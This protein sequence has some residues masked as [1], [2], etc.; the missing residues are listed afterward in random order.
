M[1]TTAPNPNK[2]TS[3]ENLWWACEDYCNS[4]F[5]A[6]RRDKTCPDQNAKKEA[7]TA[8]L[9]DERTTKVFEDNKAILRATA[10][11]KEPGVNFDFQLSKIPDTSSLCVEMKYYSSKISKM[12]A[13]GQIILHDPSYSFETYRGMR[14]L[15]NLKHLRDFA[16]SKNAKMAEM[17][18]NQQHFINFSD[19]EELSEISRI[20]N[21]NPNAHIVAIESIGADEMS[22]SL[23]RK[24]CGNSPYIKT[25]QIKV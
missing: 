18:L 17:I 10:V 1:N 14:V 4:V 8:F 11:C 20:L 3:L 25:W 23:R 24:S 2:V 7:V 12:P 22:I 5:Q 19:S 16:V 13:A 15:G 21:T 6:S 9:L